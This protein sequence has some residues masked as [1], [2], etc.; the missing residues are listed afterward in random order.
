MSR[1]FEDV[2]TWLMMGA[3]ILKR[4]KRITVRYTQSQM[5]MR[6][7]LRTAKGE[8]YTL[9]WQCHKKSTRLILWFLVI[10]TTR[11][12]RNLIRTELPLNPRPKIWDA[13]FNLRRNGT[14]NNSACLIRCLRFFY[15]DCLKTLVSVRFMSLVIT[16][17]KSSPN[18]N[19]TSIFRCR[20]V[21]TD[22]NYTLMS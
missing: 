14:D 17:L 5:N 8:R 2:I 20:A 18:H 10:F 4:L 11:C 16:K 19:V 7:T 15:V 22:N 6:C 13:I 21:F 12:P 1:E 9:N 3:T